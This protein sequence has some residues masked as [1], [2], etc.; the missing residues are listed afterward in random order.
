MC[1]VREANKARRLFDAFTLEA[2]VALEA[3]SWNWCLILSQE[4]N[5]LV[6][7][8]FGIGP[9]GELGFK[10]SIRGAWKICTSQAKIPLRK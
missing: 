7:Y 8:S 5:E 4:K 1:V 3:Y 2:G 10:V 6:G 9:Q